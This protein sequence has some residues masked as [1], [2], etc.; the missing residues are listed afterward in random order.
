MSAATI[1]R[2]LREMRT[3][4]PYHFDRLIAQLK[5]ECAEL[6]QEVDSGRQLTPVAAP[7]KSLV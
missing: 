2:L 7:G 6:P 3:A 5:T 4:M 1:D